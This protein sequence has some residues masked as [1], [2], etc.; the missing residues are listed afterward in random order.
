[1]TRIGSFAK[2]H[3]VFADDADA[4]AVAFA[5]EFIAAHRRGWRDPTKRLSDRQKAADDRAVA[6]FDAAWSWENTRHGFG[7]SGTTVY[8]HRTSGERY[9]VDVTAGTGDFWS[10]NYRITR[11]EDQ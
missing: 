8:T 6:S 7:G 10:S 5:K 9:E 4:G 1:M 2:G 11:L 3:S